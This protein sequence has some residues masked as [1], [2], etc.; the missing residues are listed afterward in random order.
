[1]TFGAYRERKS[2]LGRGAREP[3]VWAIGD[4]NFRKF[5]TGGL[6]L[7]SFWAPWCG[8]CL[9]F[10]PMFE[11]AARDNHERAGFAA[12]II[13]ASPEAAARLRVVD[14]PTV[15]FFDPGGS[16]VGRIIEA[17]PASDLTFLIDRVIEAATRLAHD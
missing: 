3:L 10:A 9:T 8:P 17:L 1:M 7:V 5:T 12:C 11:E 2:L 4:S 13:D 14:I 15:V 6:T 16:E